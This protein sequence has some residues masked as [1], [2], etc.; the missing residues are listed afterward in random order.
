VDGAWT[1]GLTVRAV[2]PERPGSAAALPPLP[3]SVPSPVGCSHL[4]AQPKEG[5]FG[6]QPRRIAVLG[7]D[8]PAQG[9]SS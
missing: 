8:G 1:G 9:S 5:L 6:E 4:I 3:G 2:R 7:R